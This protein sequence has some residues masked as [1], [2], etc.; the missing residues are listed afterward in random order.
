[1][2]ASAVAGTRRQPSG[3]FVGLGSVATDAGALGWPARW[4]WAA[5]GT[6]RSGRV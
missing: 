2:N 4:D 1:M 5:H 3:S 6:R